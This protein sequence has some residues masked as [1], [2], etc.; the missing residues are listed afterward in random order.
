MHIPGACNFNN[1]PGLEPDLQNV[2]LRGFGAAHCLDNPNTRGKN[3][4]AQ[5]VFLTAASLGWMLDVHREPSRSMHTHTDC[6]GWIIQPWIT[7]SMK[8]DRD[9]NRSD[10][11]TIARQQN[12]TAARWS[13]LP[14][15]ND[16]EDSA[17]LIFESTLAVNVSTYQRQRSA[18]LWQLH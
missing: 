10:K 15:H 6:V 12:E 2:P 17:S 13:H 18:D 11:P 16:Q 9:T 7:P 14:Q 8:S 3:S 4:R 1:G 5:F